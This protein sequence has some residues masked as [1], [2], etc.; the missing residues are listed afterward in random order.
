MIVV[1]PKEVQLVAEIAC[2]AVIEGALDKLAISD[3][4]KFYS[5]LALLLDGDAAEEA[6]HN[7]FLCAEQERAQLRLFERI[8]QS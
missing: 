3:R 7:A 2:A 6:R 8:R 5:Q 1:A 4:A